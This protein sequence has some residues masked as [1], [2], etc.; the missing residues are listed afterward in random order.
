M[1][2]KK[3][4]SDFKHVANMNHFILTWKLAN[5]CLP[6]KKMAFEIKHLKIRA[7]WYVRQKYFP[8]ASYICPHVALFS[9]SKYA[10]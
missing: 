4:S 3:V 9:L 2:V 6:C 10:L 1:N 7:E 8:L 5:H